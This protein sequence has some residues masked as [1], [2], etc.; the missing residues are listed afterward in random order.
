MKRA[1]R[2][3]PLFFALGVLA[4]AWP[5]ARRATGDDVKARP[6]KPLTPPFTVNKLDILG[7]LRARQFDALDT[8]LR[9][10]QQR[11]EENIAEE[12]NMRMAFQTFE[13][14]DPGLDD[15]LSE[16]VKNSAFSYS[17]HL[18]WATYS[19]K[20]GWRARGGR[21]AG[22][23]SAQRVTD[24]ESFFAHGAREAQAALS[25]NPKLAQAYV[26][27]L[28]RERANGGTEKCMKV[29]ESVLNLLPAS[30]I[31]RLE[32]MKCLQPRWGGSVEAMEAFAQESQKFVAENARLVVLKGFPAFDR[33]SWVYRGKRD[34]ALEIKVYAEAIEK[35]GDDA[36]FYQARGEVFGT[37]G[38]TQQAIEDFERANQLSPQNQDIL[39]SLAG[40]QAQIGK[41]EEALNT[42]ELASRVGGPSPY[43]PDL[44]AFLLSK[45]GRRPKGQGVGGD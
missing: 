33:A 39:E 45:L 18:A 12:A 31:V 19:F 6:L 10:Y 2:R 40:V 22:D 17:A 38:Q 29:G 37:L 1:R 34:Y 28:Q 26:L 35:G 43:A 20:Q 14:S 36:M 42:L 3:I 4:V 13:N 30:F 5:L 15:L 16:W 8:R 44:R 9:S 24:M 27:L 7:D 32:M 23:T 25:L 21:V 41:Y 11:A